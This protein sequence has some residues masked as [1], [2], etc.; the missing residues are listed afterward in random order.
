MS[1]PACRT[2]RLTLRRLLGLA[3]LC[4]SPAALALDPQR[5]VDEYTVTAWTM[6]DGLP[7]NLV[8]SIGQDQ[9]G[10]LWIGTWEGA[11]RFNGR[12]FSAFDA[13]TVPGMQIAGV[14]SI[15]PEADGSV[16]FGTAQFGVLQ[17][18]AGRWTRVAEAALGGLAVSTLHRDRAGELWIGTESSLFRLD[19]QGRVQEPGQDPRLNGALTYVLLQDTDGAMLVGNSRG[20][21]RMTAGGIEDLGRRVGL[22]AEAVRGLVR[23]RDGGLWVAGDGGVWH[24]HDGRAVPL[25][26][27]RV[28]AVLDDRDGNLWMLRAAGGLVRRGADGLQVLGERHGLVG[29]GS[30]AL[31]EDREGLIWAGTTNGLFRISDGAV[32]GI[33]TAGGL[34]DDYVRT[35]LQA[36][37]GGIWIGHAS[38]LDLW[39]DG[40]PQRVR[41]AADGQPQP[42][43]MALA[44]DAGGRILVGTYDQGVLGVLAGDGVRTRIDKASGLPSDHVRA[45]L[46]DRDGS[47]WIGTG[48][49]LVRWR[50]GRPERI[51]GEA[52]GLPARFVRTLYQARDG[53]VWIGT[54][55][56]IAALRRDGTLRGW[57]PADGFPAVGSFD[58]L[59]DADG[60]LWIASDR[61]VL[62]M[63]DGRFSQY[64]HRV[65]LP[66]DTVLRILDDG[67]GNLWLSSNYGVFR[68]PRAGF[69]EVD[70]GTRTQLVV[71]VFDHNDGMP[72]S[73]ANG[74]SAPAGWRMRDGRLWFPT[75]RGVVVID[76]TVASRQRARDTPLLIEAAEV[77]GQPLPLD[78]T[79][80]LPPDARRLTVHYAAISLRA[81]GKL[82]YRYRLSGFEHAWVD[83]G[84]G[85]EAAYTNLPPGRF[86]FEVQATNAPADWS[87]TVAS[88]GFDLQ[89]EPP[90]WYRFWFLL[91]CAAGLAV[92]A[93][94]VHLGM[95]ARQRAHRRR[96]RALVEQGTRELR[97]K[98]EALERSDREREAL[99]QQLAWQA[100]H[101][102]LTGLPNRRAGD[103]RLDQAIAAAEATGAPLCVALIDIDHFKR[104]ND[105]HGHA[106]GDAVLC[107]VAATMGEFA[108]RQA[109]F[110]SRHGGEEFLACMPGRHLAQAEAAMA[111]LAAAIAGQQL[112]LDDGASLHCTVSAGVAAL[113][114]GQSAHALLAVADQRLHEAKQQGRD[115][116]VAG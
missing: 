44:E 90:F 113:V 41:L 20:L 76:P 67:A 6:E 65:G 112:R 55:G 100:T 91:S 23:A 94:L 32:Y 74:S 31:F 92:L 109:I 81:P 87:G 84:G 18:K 107:R 34:G 5:S 80:V 97:L 29:R 83:A 49:G 114:P 57:R 42:S 30:P 77:D 11:A 21:F 40:Q 10:L 116:I 111:M 93:V 101:D 71:E 86:R 27:E 60:T 102:T 78:V 79:P 75:A 70:R 2:V 62:R 14:R 82:R 106:A 4:L 39:R 53:T 28:E 43:V 37:D 9:A 47:V 66:R 85:T 8:H 3:L 35:I 17:R 58:F 24:L 50:D 54:S 95:T 36:R 1:R 98:N 33:G 12:Q 103:Q 38:G 73:Q 63:R 25:L 88:A 89:V 15:L 19:A 72:S 59:E 110:I 104:V 64:D 115:R 96:L 61:G 7:H 108:E 56:G 16:L 46:Q 48:G 26:R 51:Y 22:P 13:T 68:I 52:D 45:I 105:R 99:M 69:D